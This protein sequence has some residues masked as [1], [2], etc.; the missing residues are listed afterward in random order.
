M[1]K[2]LSLAGVFLLAAMLAL[3]W[4]L[5]AQA[6]PASADSHP[7]VE[8]YYKIAPGKTEAWLALYRSQHLPV[9]KQ[10]Q[11][12]GHILQIVVYRPFLHQGEPAWDFKV[13][14]TYRDFAALGD[15]AGFE[16][17]ERRLF[18]DWDTHQRAER[19]RWEITAKHW[20][21]IMVAM[22]AD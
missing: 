18:P 21:D 19:R 6:P 11:R 7:V 9:L 14:L 22:P 16:A 12:D 8:S 17:I 3:G 10:R 5:E 15:R 13:I 4:G 2:R 20:D 1:Q